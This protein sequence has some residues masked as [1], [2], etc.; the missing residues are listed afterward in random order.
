MSDTTPRNLAYLRALGAAVLALG[1][2]CGSNEPQVPLP[3]VLEQHTKALNGGQGL[4][5]SVRE[6]VSP[7]AIEALIDAHKSGYALVQVFTYWPPN[8]PRSGN[9]E[10]RWEWTLGGR[11]V[12]RTQV[13]AV[14]G[15]VPG[16]VR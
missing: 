14:G 10:A 9:P 16:T 11:E 13:S 6:P 12:T 4:V 15:M 3:A 1:I 8:E 5:L 2:G 7:V